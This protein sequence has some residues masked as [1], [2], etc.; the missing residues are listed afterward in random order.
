MAPEKSRE[1]AENNAG[2][3]LNSV[4]PPVHAAFAIRPRRLRPGQMAPRCTGFHKAAAADQAV[5]CG[6]RRQR[7]RRARRRVAAAGTSAISLPRTYRLAAAGVD[8][9]R[10]CGGRQVVPSICRR[11]TT[12]RSDPGMASQHRRLPFE[13]PSLG[14]SA[15]HDLQGQLPP[16]IGINAGRLESHLNPCSSCSQSRDRRDARATRFDPSQVRVMN[17]PAESVERYFGAV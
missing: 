15:F 14:P 7:E 3:A 13:L 8:R 4:Y 11:V 9:E 2:K 10:P 6:R 1:I 16:D 12:T 5:S 17:G